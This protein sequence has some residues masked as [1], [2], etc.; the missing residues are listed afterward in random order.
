MPGYT[1]FIPNKYTKCGESHYGHVLGNPSKEQG[2]HPKSREKGDKE[3]HISMR[4][5]PGYSAHV[6]GA[7]DS[8]GAATASTYDFVNGGY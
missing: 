1:G 2:T 6:P 8:F 4:V 5:K 7:R 3:L